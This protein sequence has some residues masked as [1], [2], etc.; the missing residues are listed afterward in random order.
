MLAANGCELVTEWWKN[1]EAHASNVALLSK[2]IAQADV[3][4]LDMRSPDFGTHHFAGSYLGAGIALAAGKR[5]VVVVP[6]EQK[7][8][9]S[10]LPAVTSDE[11]L[12]RAV[13]VSE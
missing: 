6:E 10:L 11:D 2:Q 9:T 13:A 4:V 3:Y 1:K 8:Y 7:G 12:L 5:V